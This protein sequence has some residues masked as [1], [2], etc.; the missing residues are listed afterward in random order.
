[1]A[2]EIPNAVVLMRD[3]T[4]R[5]WVMAASCYQATQVLA[6]PG[7]ADTAAGKMANEVLL[8]PT[9]PVLNRL[10]SILST[11]NEISSRGADVNAVGQTVLL[12]QLAV[13]WEPLANVL[14][15]NVVTS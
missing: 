4:F 10:V 14:Y 5:D 11:R 6:T 12:A 1:M 2:N 8:N 9:G 13:V 3:S 15:P 7:N